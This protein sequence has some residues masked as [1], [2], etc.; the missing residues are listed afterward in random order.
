MHI[1]VTARHNKNGTVTR[2][3]QLAQNVWDSRA[4]RAAPRIIYNFGRGDEVDKE[5]LRR[6][7]RSIGRFLGE[8]FPEVEGVG[9]SG[10]KYIGSKTLGGAW[11][12]NALWERLGIKRA[13]TG[14]LTEHHYQAPVERAL[15]ALVANRAL[16]PS[17][18]L[19]VEDWVAEEVALPGLA[20][21]AVQQLYRAM[22]FLLEHQDE[23][24]WQVYTSVADLFNLEVDILYFD[25]TSTYFETEDEDEE[26]TDGRSLRKRGYSKDHRPD[27]PQAVIGMAVTRTG[28]PV[29]CWIWPGNTADMSVVAQVKKDL[30]GWKLG[31]VITVVDR[32]FVSEDNLK[33]LQKAGGHYIAGEKLRSGKAETEAALGRAGRYQWIKEGVEVKEIVIGEGEARQR[34]VV[35]RNKK[36]AERDRTVRAELLK[37]L[38]E[39]LKQIR[40]LKG[41][42]HSKACC[43]L[44]A[45]SAYSRYLKTNKS[46]QPRIDRKKV[47]DESKLDGRYLI[48]TSDDTLSAGDV[49]L[50]Y[51]QLA[52]V[53]SAFR[54]LKHELDLRPIYHRL[55]DR[56]RSHVLLCWLALLLIRVAENNTGATWNQLGRQLERMRLGEFSG[57]SGRV[58]QRSEPTPYHQIIFKTMNIP[59]PPQVFLAETPKATSAA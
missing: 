26:D 5:A 46:G 38:E 1:R 24:Q 31:R 49:A 43:A 56:I 19:A 21:V 8:P 2:Y 41:Q 40:V 44:L 58:L 16:G 42:P 52:E 27:L 4:R 51:K 36:R 14:M 48:R 37:R 32:G 6:L 18:K 39:E 22:D 59:L 57:S 3:V 30:I 55:E 15:F 23:L 12:L 28:I 13:L 20:E 54:S 53:E 35:V 7:A 34:Y 11:V 10:L 45:N 9:T 47:R 33:E 25:T 50:G 29:R 17:S